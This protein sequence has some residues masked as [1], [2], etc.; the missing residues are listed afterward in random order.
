VCDVSTEDSIKVA[1]DAKEIG[2]D[3]IFLMPP[4]GALDVTIGWDTERYP[5]VWID[6]AKAQVE[7]MLL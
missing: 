5:E 6:M 1:V 7:N 2:V 4:I 3:G